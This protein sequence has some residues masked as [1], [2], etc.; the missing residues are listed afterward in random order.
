MGSNWNV[1]KKSMNYLESLKIFL[2]SPPV[3][4]PWENAMITK[5]V[6]ERKT[7]MFQWGFTCTLIIKIQK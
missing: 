5:S 4:L 7:Y 1:S 2:K 3:Y 6:L